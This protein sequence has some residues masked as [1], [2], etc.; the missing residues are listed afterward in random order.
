MAERTAGWINERMDR[1]P[2]CLVFDRD[3]GCS[4]RGNCNNNSNNNFNEGAMIASTTANQCEKQ[5]LRLWS[6]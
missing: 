1:V 3:A 6:N 2:N 4:Y 5:K